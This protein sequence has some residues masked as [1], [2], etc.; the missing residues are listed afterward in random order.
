VTHQREVIRLHARRRGP[1]RAAFLWLERSSPP[2][3]RLFRSS[4]SLFL[5]TSF[6]GLRMSG[7]GEIP[8]R[9]QLAG[10]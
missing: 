5:D 2:N 3:P 8:D 1:T 4:I 9:P 7:L 6:L 10:Q